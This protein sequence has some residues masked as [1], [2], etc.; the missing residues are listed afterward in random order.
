MVNGISTQTAIQSP[1]KPASQAVETQYTGMRPTHEFVARNEAL[2]LG[3]S[4][5]MGT[6]LGLLNAKFDLAK[7]EG[8]S[9][10]FKDLFKEAELITTFGKVGKTILGMAG[11]LYFGDF[12]FQKIFKTNKEYE[13]MYQEDLKA[14]KK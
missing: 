12:I 2:N 8:I 1:V 14:Q 11:L 6:V 4:V 5:V 10:K 13:E 3:G 9:A 7:R